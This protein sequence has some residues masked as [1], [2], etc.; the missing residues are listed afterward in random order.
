MYAS[1]AKMVSHTKNLFAAL[2]IDHSLKPLCGFD[3]THR[4]HASTF[5][6]NNR[7]YIQERCGNDDDDDA[8]ANGNPS[9]R[10]VNCDEL[11]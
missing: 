6:P 3:Q 4:T 9:I 7:N 8:G 2:Q 1:H 10:A 11:A 5:E